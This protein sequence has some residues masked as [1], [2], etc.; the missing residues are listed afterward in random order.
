MTFLGNHDVRRFMGE[1]GATPQKLGLAFGLL[2]T[3]RGIPHCMPVT[4]LACPAGTTPIT[5]AI[6]PAD[7]RP[8]AAERLY[9]QGRS[10]DEQQLFEQVRRLLRLREQHPA[11][12]R[13]QYH[14]IFSDTRPSLLFVIFPVKGH[15]QLI[16]NDCLCS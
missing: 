14:H 4:R 8:H 15:R 13:G 6:S 11:L 16:G 5:A 12:R 3:V 9:S 1:T 2:L 7:F 10:A